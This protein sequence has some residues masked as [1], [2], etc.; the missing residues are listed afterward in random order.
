[1]EP[2][3]K[4]LTSKDIAAFTKLLRVFED[5]FELDP[6]PLPDQH[7]LQQLLNDKNFFVYVALQ[8]QN[9]LGGLTAY[10]LAQYHSTRP[11]VYIHDLAVATDRQRQGIGKRLVSAL[12][13]QCREIGAEGMF[14]Q[15]E[16]EDAHAIDFYRA[17]GSPGERIYHFYYPLNTP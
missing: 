2:N 14:V 15:A 6:L 8:N 3:I 11:L 4:K 1:M 17:T 16:E 13:H 5:V 9:V 7:Y 12:L 10:R